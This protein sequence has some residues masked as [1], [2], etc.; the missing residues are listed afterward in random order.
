MMVYPQADCM[1]SNQCKYGIVYSQAHRYMQRCSF[2]S[3]FETLSA[4]IAL[5][6]Y[7]VT[8]KKYRLS[9]CMSQFNCFCT[10]FNH[11]FGTNTGR[12]TFK[13]VLLAIKKAISVASA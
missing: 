11:K 3:D 6:T 12:Y 8:T 5:I 1:L 4:V 2:C 7:L 13:K 9:L 10:K